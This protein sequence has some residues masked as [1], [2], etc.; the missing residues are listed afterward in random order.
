MRHRSAVL[1]YKSTVGFSFFYMIHRLLQAI[2]YKNYALFH[3][4]LLSF[5]TLINQT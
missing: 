5:L 1:H 4:N 3:S 2:A